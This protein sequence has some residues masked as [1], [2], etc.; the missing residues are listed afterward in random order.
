MNCNIV[1]L[2]A[3]E[4]SDSEFIYS[5]CKEG[6]KPNFALFLGAESIIYKH[7]HRYTYNVYYCMYSIYTEYWYC[8]MHVRN[9]QSVLCCSISYAGNV[10]KTHCLVSWTSGLCDIHYVPMTSLKYTGRSRIW[11]LD[12]I[13]KRTIEPWTFLTS[14]ESAFGV[15]VY[16]YNIYIYYVESIYLN[17]INSIV[18]EI[19]FWLI[20]YYTYQVSLHNVLCVYT[21]IIIICVMESMQSIRHSCVILSNNNTK[22]L[23]G[24]HIL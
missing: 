20:I 5:V 14:I 17:W 12:N 9:L 7:I 16:Y 13:L 21:Y 24:M 19:L 8:S 4:K 3:N 15:W 10:S 2:D 1:F 22:N 6:R 11:S 23:F 18:F